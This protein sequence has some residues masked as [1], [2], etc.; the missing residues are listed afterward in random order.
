MCV[1]PRFDFPFCFNADAECHPI[2]HIFINETPE[3][4]FN[5]IRLG[6]DQFALPFGR[7]LLAKRAQMAHTERGIRQRAENQ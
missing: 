4:V 2:L 7:S 5:F 6:R 3:E 1:A